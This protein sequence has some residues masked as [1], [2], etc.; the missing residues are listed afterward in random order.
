MALYERHFEDG[1]FCITTR[2]WGFASVAAD[3]QL[4]NI[5]KQIGQFTRIL[6]KI[7]PNPSLAVAYPRSSLYLQAVPFEFEAHS[8]TRA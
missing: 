4:C 8:A 7:V 6:A 1:K 2:G 5:S 3:T